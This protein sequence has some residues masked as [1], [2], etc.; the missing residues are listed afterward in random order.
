MKIETF[1]SMILK[2]KK[3]GCEA[4]KLFL[5]IIMIIAGLLEFPGTLAL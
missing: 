4:V 1:E 2:E 3:I 5:R